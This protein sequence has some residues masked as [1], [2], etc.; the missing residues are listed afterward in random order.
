[1]SQH[2]P[3]D[4]HRQEAAKP[5]RMQPDAKIL[6]HER[7][8]K[9]EIACLELSD[10]LEDQRCVP[11]SRVVLMYSLAPDEIEGRVGALRKELLARTAAP[12]YAVPTYREQ[13]NL[14][15]S[16]T[17]A[18][19]AAKQGETARMQRALGVSAGYAEGDAFDRELQETRR[20]ERI[21]ER[22]RR[23]E[24]RNPRE[25][26]GRWQSPSR[27][28]VRSSPL[29]SRASHSPE[30]RR[31]ARYPSHTPSPPARRAVDRSPSPPTR[32]VADRSPSHTPEP[33]PRI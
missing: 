17:H 16:N 14:R 22:E 27:E 1:M 31:N 4:L 26:R 23:S 13:K 7:R 8:R 24:T 30:P 33:P 15:P 19:G 32:H 3:L 11:Y 25:S 6:D 5:Q 20:L 28:R 12:A 2:S 18:L 10:E 21:T 9:V 29:Y